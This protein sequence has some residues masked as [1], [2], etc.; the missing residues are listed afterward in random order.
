M[1]MK[2]TKVNRRVFVKGA[3]IKKGAG[4]AS[5]GVIGASWLGSKMGILEALPGAK[6]LGLTPASRVRPS[7]QPCGSCVAILSR[8]Y[9]DCLISDPEQHRYDYDP[10]LNKYRKINK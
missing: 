6:S 4:I 3:G 8:R 9:P 5:L 7:Q 2:N 10:N 1:K